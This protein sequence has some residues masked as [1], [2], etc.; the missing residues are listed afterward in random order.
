[1]IINI[2]IK[3]P[4]WVKHF[5]EDID[6]LLEVENSKEKDIPIYDMSLL[7]LRIDN[8]MKVIK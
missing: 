8:I 6:Y 1:M 7:I 4:K 2:L 5:S 3:D